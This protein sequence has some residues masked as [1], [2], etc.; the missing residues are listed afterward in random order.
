LLINWLEGMGGDGWAGVVAWLVCWGM[1]GGS[2][3]HIHT[4]THTHRPTLTGELPDPLLGQEEN[5]GPPNQ[6]Y[7]HT[8]IPTH[9]HI[10]IN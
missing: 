10:S 6:K 8:S 7:K 1:G 3:T 5:R 9:T 2:H 4:Y